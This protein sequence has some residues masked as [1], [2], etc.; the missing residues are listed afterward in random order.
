[1]TTPDDERYP[2]ETEL[3]FAAQHSGHGSI[4]NTTTIV[5]GIARVQMLCTCGQFVI[6]REAPES[7]K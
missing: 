7:P 5:D 1:M 3:A 2:Q 4:A 6:R